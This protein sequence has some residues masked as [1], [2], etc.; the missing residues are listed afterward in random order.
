MSATK[1]LLPRL[2]PQI[3]V[4]E[5]KATTLVVVHGKNVTCLAFAITREKHFKTIVGYDFNN[6]GRDQLLTA[7]L[8]WHHV[9]DELPDDKVRV[10]IACNETGEPLFGFYSAGHWH[11]EDWDEIGDPLSVYAWA[12]IPGLPAKKGEV[13]A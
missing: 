10:L 2:S 1:K 5:P 11:K 8:D 4:V 12:H 6:R 13:A 9:E 7:L 3:A